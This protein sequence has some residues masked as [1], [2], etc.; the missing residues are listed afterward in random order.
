M[1]AENYTIAINE[2]FTDWDGFKEAMAD[3]VAASLEAQ[4]GGAVRQFPEIKI[5]D[6]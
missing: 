4:G 3:K 6:D 1:L 2:Y 5:S